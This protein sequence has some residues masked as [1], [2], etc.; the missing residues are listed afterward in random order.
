MKHISSLGLALCA[1]AATATTAT[2]AADKYPSKPVRLVVPFSPGGGND[3]AARFVAVRLT[4]GFNQSAVVDNR[5]GAGSTLGTDL[6]AK[7]VPDGYTLLVTHNAIAINQTLYSKLPYDTTRDLTQVAIIGTTTNTLVVNPGVPVKTT[8][9]L[10]AL[11]KA[12][13]GALNYASTGGGGTSH[14]AME[15]FRIET[16]TNLVHIPYKG[17]AP[18]LTDVVG[19]QVQVMISALPGTVPFINSKRVVAL[20][21]TG[22]TRWSGLPDLPSIAEAGFPSVVYAPSVGFL[23]PSG[24]PREIVNRINAEV[25]KGANDPE[26]VKTFYPRWGLDPEILSADAFHTRYIGEIEAFRKVVRDA[27]I[28]QID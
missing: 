18:G 13:P 19:N 3:I 27:K 23:A 20:A 7:S 22:K 2:H 6:V 16:G 4:E 26:M 25:A 15:Y 5:P 9:E 10:I 24:T 11:A 12:K 17:T 1:L 14:L 28:P 8:K 21:T